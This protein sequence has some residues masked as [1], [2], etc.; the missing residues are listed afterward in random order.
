MGM[1]SRSTNK[2]TAMKRFG[3]VFVVLFVVAPTAFAE[4]TRSDAG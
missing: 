1:A 3:V 4:S 2:R